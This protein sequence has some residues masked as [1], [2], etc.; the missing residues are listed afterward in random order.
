MVYAEEP[1]PIEADHGK[2]GTKLD[3][4]RERMH[5]GGHGGVV[6]HTVGNTQQVLSDDHMSGGRDGK[7][8]C[9]SLHDSDDDSLKECHFPASSLLRPSFGL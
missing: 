2:D 6:L 1:F 3:D 8:L 4:K 5:K 7:E 9:E